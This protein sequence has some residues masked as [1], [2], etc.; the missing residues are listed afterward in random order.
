M[1]IRDSRARPSGVSPSQGASIDTLHGNPNLACERNLIEMRMRKLSLL[2]DGVALPLL[3]GLIAAPAV[4]GAENPATVYEGNDTLLRPKNYREW[5]FVGSSLGLEY[6]GREGK[7]QSPELEFKNV[8]IDPAAYREFSK[9]GVFPQGTVLVLETAT[10]ATK[11]E[12]DLKGSFQAEFLGLSAA[13][14]DQ[15]RFAEGWAYFGFTEKGGRPKEKAQPFSKSACFDC[16][17]KR[18]AHD[19]V[20]TQFYPV[21]GTLLK[22]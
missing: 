17:Q 18:G 15:K 21:L 9:T 1:P 4:S 14:K 6:D 2:R 20:F 16:H 19:N 11:K 5:V 3:L 10:S 8:Y 7:K 12:P 22:K 13:V